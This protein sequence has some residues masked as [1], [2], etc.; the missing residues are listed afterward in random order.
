MPLCCI[1]NNLPLDVSVVRF[2]LERK[3]GISRGV[4]M[5]V[6]ND[7]VLGQSPEVSQS[8]VHLLRSTLEEP[9]ASALE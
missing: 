8:L 7:R 1:S 5:T 9:S 2:D 4:L 3:L 6:V